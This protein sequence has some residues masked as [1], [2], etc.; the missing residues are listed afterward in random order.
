MMPPPSALPLASS[1][2]SMA[3][4]ASAALDGTTATTT[5]PP[6]HFDA[7]LR[8]E[9]AETKAL[10]LGAERTRQHTEY[11]TLTAELSNADDLVSSLDG[12]LRQ[13]HEVLM[14]TRQQLVHSEAARGELREARQRAEQEASELK[15]LL[16]AQ[17]AQLAS[18]KAHAERLGSQ[19]ASQGAELRA[20]TAKI[21]QHRDAEAK[22]FGERRKVW[23][24][25]VEGWLSDGY[26][27]RIDPLLFNS[28]K[29][30]FTR[31]QELLVQEQIERNAQAH[32][33]DQSAALELA[34]VREALEARV[35]SAEAELAGLMA[36]RH[37]FG[38]KLE[39]ALTAYLKGE[40]EAREQRIGS[41]EH[42]LRQSHQRLSRLRETYDASTAARR[43]ALDGALAPLTQQVSTLAE[44]STA[45]ARRRQQFADGDPRKLLEEQQRRVVDAHEEAKR[46]RLARERLAAELQAERA[47]HAAAKAQLEKHAGEMASRSLEFGEKE[48][49]QVTVGHLQ[50]LQRAKDDEMA[51]AVAAHASRLEA[52][53]ERSANLAAELDDLR[54]QRQ[55]MALSLAQYATLEAEWEKEREASGA[56]SRKLAKEN[57][58]LRHKASKVASLVRPLAQ[59]A[60]QD[61]KRKR[62]E[63][64]HVEARL[65]LATEQ[66]TSV[67]TG[68]AELQAAYDELKAEKDA[69]VWLAN[70]QFAERADEF[71]KYAAK[72]KHNLARRVVAAWLYRYVGRCYKAWWR[73][74]I[75]RQV[76]RRIARARHRPPAIAAA[77]A[78]AAAAA[79]AAA[80]AA[81]VAEEGRGERRRGGG[82]GSDAD[83]EAEL[84]SDDESLG[85]TARPPPMAPPARGR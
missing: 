53:E 58:A 71:Q 44:E 27:K 21:H 59:S 84:L 43:S 54:K 47:S 50:E 46:E 67:T 69:S 65:Q 24:R 8:A 33:L 22:A 31:L 66:L 39:A 73:Y 28:N 5:A 45:L 36:A 10:H 49:Y 52:S 12:A 26:S 76:V 41:L 30:V 77:R 29:D 85:A 11:V 57:K 6:A 2:A 74:V 34:N 4:P 37:D 32:Y 75:Q 40:L 19:L 81:V 60:H 9:L 62:R 80:R 70:E 17:A 42:E 63:A 55:T 25:S 15:L 14:T 83:L 35:A 68:K 20:A 78:A 7:D 16:E 56:A 38:A 82:G 18:S 51:E 48:Y 1:A 79:A 61:Q 23:E 72:L 3:L 64:Q 13:Q